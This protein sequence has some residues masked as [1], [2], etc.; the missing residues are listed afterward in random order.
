MSRVASLVYLA[1]PIFGHGDNECIKWRKKATELLHA[2]GIM[3][4]DPMKD[5]YR[6]LETKTDV[7]NRIVKNDKSRLMSCDT[8]LA[9]SPAPS[10]GTAMEIYFAW[11]LHKQILTISEHQSPW[12]KFHSCET[13]PTI[14]RALETLS[15]A[16]NAK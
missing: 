1:G 13:Y 7:A 2:K 4:L 15:Y 12:L 5:D 11:S 9:Y 8:V 16:C 6:G 10:Y 14:E 3:T